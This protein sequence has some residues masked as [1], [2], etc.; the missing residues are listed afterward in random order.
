MLALLNFSPVRVMALKRGAGSLAAVAEKRRIAERR[1]AT[2]RGRRD[3]ARGN[4]GSMYHKAKC[5]N[6]EGKKDLHREHG[7]HR[8]HGEAGGESVR[9]W[10][11]K[12]VHNRGEQPEKN[13]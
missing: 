7:G 5:R 12:K 4:M 2:T 9:G 11:K 1:A 3:L 10:K 6:Q 13:E 8:E